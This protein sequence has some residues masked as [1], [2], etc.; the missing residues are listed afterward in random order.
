M[1]GFGV[2]EGDEDA[3]AWTLKIEG[4]LLEPTV[5]GPA[6]KGKAPTRKFSTFVRKIAVE[7]DRSVIPATELNFVEVMPVLSWCGCH[8]LL[9]AFFSSSSS[10]YYS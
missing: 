1:I 3:P 6:V 5:P 4:K 9:I 7:F 8:H 10:F 2:T